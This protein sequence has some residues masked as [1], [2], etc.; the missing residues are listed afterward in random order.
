M[1][2]L[3]RARGATRSPHRGV[4]K[5]PP[6]APPAPQGP[7]KQCHKQSPTALGRRPRPH[8]GRTG[9]FFARER[10]GPPLTTT[11]GA[12]RPRLP[13]PSSRDPTV[14]PHAVRRVRGPSR[15]PPP[16]ARGPAAARASPV[17]G[18]VPPVLGAPHVAPGT[19]L[20]LL[21]S[22]LGQEQI[23]IVEDSD[24]NEILEDVKE[25]FRE[26][27]GELKGYVH[28]IC[29]KPGA[30]AVKHKDR[31]VPIVVREE[32]SG[33]LKDMIREGVIEPVEAS[34]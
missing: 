9:P 27:I 29:M 17:Q 26:E 20:I 4:A 16:A 18:L 34:N 5:Q 12:R 24:V 32:V 19:A 3:W 8:T 7:A 31:N 14:R 15:L 13:P 22:R 21:C 30:V 11:F 28:K 25:V 23:L 10:C 1:L 33:M 6:T 2:P